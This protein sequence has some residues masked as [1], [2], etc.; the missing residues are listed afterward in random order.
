MISLL[1]RAQ[2]MLDKTRVA[3]S[4]A[5]L[6]MRIFLFLP[7]WEAGM[8]KLLS[9]QS[10]VQWF[11]NAQWGLGLPFPTLMASLAIA[12]ELGGSLALLVGVATRWATIPLMVTMLVAMVTVH[13]KH[14][15]LAIAAADSYWFGQMEGAKALAEFKKWAR[16]YPEYKAVTKHGSLVVLNNGIEFA[17]TYFI[18]LLSLFFTGAGKLSVDALIAARWRR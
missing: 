15:W 1:N 17:A 2:D 4:I 10:T 5:P 8:N 14:G 16:H 13:L 18:M 3:E 9:F 12:A 11:G 6:L 7:L